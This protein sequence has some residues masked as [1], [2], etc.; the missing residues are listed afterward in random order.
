[1]VDLLSLPAALRPSLS[2]DSEEA[3][4]KEADDDVPKS[5]DLS[6][7]SSWQRLHQVLSSFFEHL[8]SVSEALHILGC[9]RSAHTSN[10]LTSC[11]QA[12]D[13]NKTL[14]DKFSKG[15]S[16]LLTAA[17]KEEIEAMFE[18]L[19]QMVKQLCQF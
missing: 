4:K 11:S 15:L 13:I 14:S 16:L 18:Q 6:I 5:C 9:S 10:S 19:L 3:T 1:M 7:V 17:N 8:N 12:R 2:P